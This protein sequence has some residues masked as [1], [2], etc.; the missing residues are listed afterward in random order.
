MELLGILEKLVGHIAW[1]L[2]IFFIVK[3][4]SEEIKFFIRRIK[5][6]KYKDV[7]INLEEEFQTIKDKAIDAG[8]TVIYPRTT[9][10]N[11]NLQTIETVPEWAII[12]S[13]QEIEKVISQLYSTTSQANINKNKAHLNQMISVLLENEIVDQ[14]MVDL[15]NLIKVLRNEIVHQSGFELTRGEAL[16]WMGI[17]KSIMDR[18]NQRLNERRGI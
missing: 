15:I 17:S 3:Q 14:R 18:L 10:S 1:P 6:A 7:E 11:E 13:W 12:Q 16:E 5:N 9:F 4:F 2:A 8:I